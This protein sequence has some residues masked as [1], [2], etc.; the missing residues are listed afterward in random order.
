MAEITQENVLQFRMVHQDN[1]SHFEP[2]GRQDRTLQPVQEGFQ[3]PH[4]LQRSLEPKPTTSSFPLFLRHGKVFLQTAFPMDFRH[5]GTHAAAAPALKSRLYD[6][7]DT[8]IGQ[9]L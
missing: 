6:A 9:N 1:A 8:K 5:P 4:H 7:L 3:F 2:G